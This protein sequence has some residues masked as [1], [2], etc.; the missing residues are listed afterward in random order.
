MTVKNTFILTMAAWIAL[1][2]A[3]HGWL[4]LGWGEAAKTGA[5]TEDKMRIGYLP[6][7]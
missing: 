4:N 6:V 7:T 2:T 5:Q 3:L 1:V